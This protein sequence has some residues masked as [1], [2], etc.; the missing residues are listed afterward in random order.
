MHDEYIER[1]SVC[2]SYIYT[3]AL[4]RL[5]SMMGEQLSCE[6]CLKGTKNAA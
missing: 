5:Q 4:Q 3:T 2:G 6:F 1:C